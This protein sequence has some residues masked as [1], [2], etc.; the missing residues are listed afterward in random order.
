MTEPVTAYIALGSNLGDREST[1]RRALELLGRHDAVEV[2]RTSALRETDPVGPP[3]Q[4]LYI[5]AAAALRTTLTA[6]HL[7]ELLLEIERQLGRN[8]TNQQKWGPR[9]IDLDL[10]LYDADVMDEPGLVVPHPH[11]NER[12]FVLEPLAEIA[13]DVEHPVTGQTIEQMRLALL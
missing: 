6:R 10:L 7:L 13:G 5:N 11:M 12:P 3:N 4:P 1:V 8:R 9:R 2:I